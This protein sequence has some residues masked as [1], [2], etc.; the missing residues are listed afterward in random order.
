[1]FLDHESLY[2]DLSEK[3]LTACLVCGGQNTEID[4]QL[5]PLRSMKPD[6]KGSKT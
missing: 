2:D 4:R 6:V 5:F 3:G 1:V